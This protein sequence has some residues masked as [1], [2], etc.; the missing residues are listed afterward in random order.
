MTDQIKQFV[1]ET[2]GTSIGVLHT[3]EHAQLN[4]NL[5]LCPLSD[6]WIAK[7][8]SGNLII[9]ERRTMGGET[10]ETNCGITQ[11]GGSGL[12]NMIPMPTH[13]T[14][15]C[16]SE[17]SVMRT[18]GD[19]DGVLVCFRYLS[20]EGIEYIMNDPMI[21]AKK[22][23]LDLD[24][25]WVDQ[26]PVFPKCLAMTECNGDLPKDAVEQMMINR[27]LDPNVKRYP[28]TDLFANPTGSEHWIMPN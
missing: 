13:R 10:Y 12:Y 11:V 19:H 20:K 27:G 21:K 5:S 7:I 16:A 9:V 17:Q 28:P 22:N 6:E 18:G 4:L 26:L 14:M 2:I 8:K 23:S 1:R 15:L 24:L 3:D 25:E